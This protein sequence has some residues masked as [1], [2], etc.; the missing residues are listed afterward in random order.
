LI[1]LTEILFLKE[2]N[3]ARVWKTGKCKP[4]T[5]PR[6]WNKR[7][8]ENKTSN[9]TSSAKKPRGLLQRKGIY[10]IFWY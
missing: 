3:M 10:Q 6:L 5:K 2:K 8:L 4:E 1:D 9:E 7:E